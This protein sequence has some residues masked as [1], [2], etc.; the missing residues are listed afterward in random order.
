M[1]NTALL[2]FLLILTLALVFEFINGFHDTANSIATSISTRVLTPR[3][4]IIM[5]ALLNLAGAL[6]GSLTSAAVVKTISG[7]IVSGKVEVY[8]IGSAVV[9]AIIWNL[10]TWY[11]GI[12]SSSSHALIGALVGATIGDTL[13]TKEVIWSGVANKV[14]IPLF[15]SPILGMVAGFIL[16]NLL[17]EL[18]RKFSLTMVNK[19]FSK[20][21]IVSAALMAFSHGSN[22]AQKTIGIIVMALMSIDAANP[23]AI[24]AFLLPAHGAAVPIWVVICCAVIMALGTSVGGYRIMKTVGMNMIKMQPI[25]GF[26]AQTAAA[27]VIQGA[28]M[29]GAPVSTTHVVTSSIIGVGA[30][31]RLSSVRWAVVRDMVVSWFMTIPICMLIGGV[32]VALFKLIFIH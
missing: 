30:S 23:S 26:A 32:T 11:F 20:L 17:F 4:A 19:W 29:L 13:S 9:A 6:F 5:A 12:P 16:M 22:D 3:N 15:T 14:V 27:L 25:D 7:G 18:L 21:Q 2:S 28:T 24:P 8:V 31:K 1:L 10:V